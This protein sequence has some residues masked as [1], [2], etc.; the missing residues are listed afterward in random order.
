MTGSDDRYNMNGSSE[1]EISEQQEGS[2]Q[3][4]AKRLLLMALFLVLL[5]TTTAIATQL[6]SDAVLAVRIPVYL[7]ANLINGALALLFLRLTGM[8]VTID[9]KNIRQYLVGILLA[10]ALLAGISVFQLLGIQVFEHKDLVLWKAFYSFLNLILVIGPVEELAFRE[11]IQGTF[12]SLFKR[13]GWL[14]VLLTSLLFGLW[15]FIFSGDFFQLAFTT[16]IGAAIGFVRL[17]IKNGTYIAI[18]LGH[19]L[20][21]ALLGVISYLV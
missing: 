11:Y 4:T 3:S 9:L 6:F 12:L 17:R 15:H 13:Y 14:A 18:S 10:L 16:L 1:T 5:C 20:Y 19:G 21:D 8:H 7:A 2:K